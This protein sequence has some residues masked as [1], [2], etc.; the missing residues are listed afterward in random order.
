MKIP[1][2]YYDIL[3]W[4]VIIVMP[5]FITLV[6]TL[7]SIYNWPLTEVTTQTL[8]AVNLFFGV[9]LGVST[10]S[11]NKIEDKASK[12]GSETVD[13]QYDLRKDEK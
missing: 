8:A 9:I 13:S 4:V 7:G 6:Q 2:K 3:K 11:Y 12:E 5:A 10:V 1:N